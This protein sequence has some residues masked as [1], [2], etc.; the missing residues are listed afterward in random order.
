MSFSLAQITRTRRS[1]PTA[2]PAAVDELAAQA[3]AVD[4]DR[5][6]LAMA[7]GAITLRPA[8]AVRAA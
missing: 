4:R 7:L 2:V 1:R 8:A 3:A 5:D 6:A